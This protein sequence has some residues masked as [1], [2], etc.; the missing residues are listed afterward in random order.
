[1]FE[2]EHP[3]RHLFLEGRRRARRLIVVFSGFHPAKE[4]RYNYVNVAR[5]DGRPPGLRP[6]RLRSRAGATTSGPTRT[7]SSSAPSSRMLDALLD[8]ACV[9]TAPTP[10]SRAPARAA[11][12]RCTSGVRHGYRT[13]SWHGCSA[14]SDRHVPHKGGTGRRSVARGSSPARSS[15]DDLGWL[16]DVVFDA[17]ATVPH[18]RPDIELFTSDDD[19]AAARAPHADDLAAAGA[20]VP[21]TRDAGHLPAPSRG[22][23]RVPL[24]APG[25]FLRPAHPIPRRPAAAQARKQARL[26]FCRRDRPTPVL[27]GGDDR[28]GMEAAKGR[29]TAHPPGRAPDARAPPSRATARSTCSARS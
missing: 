3:V 8:R 9:S 13:A 19:N 7:S 4:W 29:A 6:R 28:A 11:P 12:R 24:S 17:A 23:D 26:G 18:H 25:A 22:G 1:M 5:R 10:C 14:D 21:G 16:D 15:P 27:R 2:A 20:R